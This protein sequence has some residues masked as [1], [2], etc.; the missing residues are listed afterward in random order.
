MDLKDLK[1][2]EKG[3]K[4]VKKGEAI[5]ELERYKLEKNTTLQCGMTMRN[6]KM[7]VLPYVY[8]LMHPNIRDINTQLFTKY[9]RECFMQAIEIMVMFDVRLEE[10]LID[11]IEVPGEGEYFFSPA[12]DTLITFSSSRKELMRNKTKVLIMQNYEGI[13]QHMLTSKTSEDYFN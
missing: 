3:V 10:K 11:F 9:E 1:T 13:K 12:I 6:F 8:Q 5:D 4:K 2:K 7:H